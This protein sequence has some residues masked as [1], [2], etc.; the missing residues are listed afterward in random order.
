M[1][2]KQLRRLYHQFGALIAYR[3]TEVQ[4]ADKLVKAG[5]IERDGA[6]YRE[7]KKMK[8]IQ[9]PYF[10][11]YIRGILIEDLLGEII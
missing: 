9:K 4:I 8:E 2:A 10:D 11:A 5:L 1:K 6:Y 3:L 7:T